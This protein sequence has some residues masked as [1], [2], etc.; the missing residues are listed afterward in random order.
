VHPNAST[1]ERHSRGHSSPAAA[2]RKLV[3]QQLDQAGVDV[4]EGPPAP[5]DAHVTLPHSATKRAYCATVGERSLRTS[6][7]CP[8]DG[9]WRHRRFCFL[10][11]VSSSIMARTR[12]ELARVSQTPLDG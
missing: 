12:I 11:E 2:V 9:G 6:C 10:L 3:G 7:R 5:A 1:L 8:P 4:A